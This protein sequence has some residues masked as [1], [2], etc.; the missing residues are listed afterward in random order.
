[1]GDAGPKAFFFG[2][3][4]VEHLLSFQ[5]PSFPLSVTAQM[6]DRLGFNLATAKWLASRTLSLIQV[7]LGS[8]S[9]WVGLHRNLILECVNIYTT[10][11][12]I[13]CL[14]YAFFVVVVLYE[15]TYSIASKPG[16]RI[17]VYTSTVK[18]VM[19]CIAVNGSPISQLWDVTCHGITQCYTCHPTPVN[20]PRL[21]P[22]RMSLT[23][24]LNLVCYL[25]SRTLRHHKIGAWHQV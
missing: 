22:R 17:V 11:E 1:M 2:G 21:N 18:K 5:F 12:L 9:W 25:G 8:E 15:L 6:P 4:D 3:G 24:V 14:H 13:H 10:Y 19:Q 23:L 20:A 16:S 7:K